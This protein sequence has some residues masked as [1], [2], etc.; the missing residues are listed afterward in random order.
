MVR[1]SGNKTNEMIDKITVKSNEVLQKMDHIIWTLDS[2]HDHL[3]DLIYF[4]RQQT[5]RFLDST[6]IE[7]SFETDGEIRDYKN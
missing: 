4:I 1:T 3:P 2:V 7:L 5:V 6:S